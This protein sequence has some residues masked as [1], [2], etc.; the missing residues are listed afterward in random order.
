VAGAQSAAQTTFQDST[1]QQEGDWNS[2]RVRELVGRSV[3]R[4]SSWAVEGELLDYRAHASG[5]IY[6]L[7]DLGLGSERHLIKADQLALDLFWRAPDRARQLIVGRREEKVLPTNIHYHLDHLTVVME[8]LGDQISLGEGSEVRDALHPAARGALDFYDY[9]L[10][11]SLTLLMPGRDVRVYRVDV[12]PRDLDGPG[13]VGSMYLDRATADIVRMDF[14]FTAASYLDETLDYFNIRLENALWEGRYWLPYRQGIELRRNI[15]AIKFPAGGVIRAE[16]RISDYEFNT[17]TPASFFRGPR[18][19]ALPSARLEAYE[20]EGDLY[21]ALDPAVAVTP[22]SLEE[23]REEATRIVR[24]S[25]LQRVEGLRL[26]VPGISSIVRYRRAEGLY[27][28]PALGQSAPGVSAL[29][30]GGY[31]IGADRWQAEGWVR[32]SLSGPYDLE[33]GFY[34]QRVADVSA[35]PASSGLIATLAALID[36]EDYREPYWANGGRA[37]LGRRLGPARASLSVAWEKWE[38][39]SLAAAKVVDRDYRE[40]RELDEGEAA[41]LSVGFER[42]PQAAVEAVGGATWDARVEA[43]TPSVAGDFEYVYGAARAEGY[44]PDLTAGIGVRVSGAAGP[45]GGRH[46]PSQRLFPAGGR[47]TVRGYSFHSFVG[48]LYGGLGIELSRAIRHPYLSLAIFADL[49]WVGSEGNGAA[50]AIDVW[51]RVGEP[52]DASSG[53]LVGVGAGLG[54]V[55]DI[56]RLELARGLRQGGIWEFVVRVRPGL[57]DWL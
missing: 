46:I 25:Y 44:W 18:V 23:I 38:G 21:D 33:L 45:A 11:D 42:A 26:A 40:V 41:W 17:G 13:L 4:R 16:F 9:R 39:A 1:G 6:F 32:A 22:P 35:W 3:T 15:K 20:F 29:A 2:P 28:G 36:G 8:N 47:G 52:V 31:A 12:R 37:T 48:N 27:L 30:L 55:Y 51:N 50:R 56:L 24:E 5:H 14:T 49:G 54:L 43:A 19:V 10:A 57:W 7:Y 53:P 34:W